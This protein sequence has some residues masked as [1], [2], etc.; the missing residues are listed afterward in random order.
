M[1]S[2]LQELL[3]ARPQRVARRDELRHLPVG[4]QRR[5]GRE[6]EIH[7]T[8]PDESDLEP[9]GGGF[10][11]RAQIGLRP[12]FGLD[13]AI[14]D[15]PRLVHVDPAGSTAHDGESLIPRSH[16]KTRDRGAQL[17]ELRPGRLSKLL[18]RP[19]L[20]R[21]SCQHGAEHVELHLETAHGAAIGL[22]IGR[23][24]GEKISALPSFGVGEV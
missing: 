15:C 13:H 11:M 22:E 4:V 23:V 5:E 1:G 9:A 24:A 8:G 14:D 7:D 20:H 10:Q 17:I 19:G 12:V 18:E 21:T 6:G 2:L 3:V 16:A